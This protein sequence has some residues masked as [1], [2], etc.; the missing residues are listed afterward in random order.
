MRAPCCLC[1][2]T[3]WSFRSCSR[4]GIEP[5]HNKAS[6]GD[7]IERLVFDA[8]EA[9]IKRTDPLAEIVI[10]SMY[11]SSIKCLVGDETIDAPRKCE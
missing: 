6:G 3:L 2:V 11:D 5:L 8:I 9:C 10:D 1:K 7:D 4:F